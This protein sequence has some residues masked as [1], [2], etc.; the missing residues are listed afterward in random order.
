M[1]V[2]LAA[3]ATLGSSASLPVIGAS[4]NKEVSS[5]APSA[6][7]E[8]QLRLLRITYVSRRCA[9]LASLMLSLCFVNV[10]TYSAEP[11]SDSTTL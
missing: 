8:S 7:T 4:C 9:L 1:I 5:V 2:A 3:V 10:D 11:S 6:A